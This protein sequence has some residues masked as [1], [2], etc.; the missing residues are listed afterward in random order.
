MSDLDCGPTLPKPLASFDPVSF[1]WRTCRRSVVGGSTPSPVTFPRSGMTCGGYLYALPTQWT[2]PTPGTVG[3]GSL[4]PTSTARDRRAPGDSRDRTNGKALNER[5]VLF[6][7]PLAQSSASPGDLSNPR[8]HTRLETQAA[9]LFKTPTANLGSGQGAAQHPDKRR[10]GGHGVN[11]QD[12]AVFTGGNWVSADGRN[13]GPAVYRWERITGR[14]APS[15]AET[16]PRGG[17]RLHA[18]F[19][20]WLM[21]LEPGRVTDPRIGLTREEQIHRIGNGVMPS[22]AKVAFT[23]LLGLL[24]TPV[25]A[26]HS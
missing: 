2:R 23:F 5:V 11:F 18:P 6:G 7:T 22:Q 14:K 1:S 9:A 19:A 21:G 13:F 4:L 10:A 16:G 15:P 3:S 20:E 24:D 12:E 17:R 8:N 25:P 26:C